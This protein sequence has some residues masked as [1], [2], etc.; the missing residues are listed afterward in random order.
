MNARS[1]NEEMA[2]QTGKQG[3]RFELDR[4]ER[5]TNSHGNGPADRFPRDTFG[6]E[7]YSCSTSQHADVEHAR[8]GGQT[9]FAAVGS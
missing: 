5:R 7:A 1:E 3:P 4:A 6:C 8:Q 9:P 2:A